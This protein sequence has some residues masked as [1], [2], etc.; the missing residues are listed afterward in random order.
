[1]FNVPYR[2]IV[3][4]IP[5]E[6]WT[7]LRDK[8]FW[9]EYMNCSITCFN[10]YLPK[11]LKK[12]LRKT[13]ELKIGIICILHPFGKDMKFYPHLHLLITEDG[14]DKKGKFIKVKYFPAKAFRRCWQYVVLDKFQELGL[15]KELATQLYQI[16]P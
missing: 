1:M 14:F 6:L 3:F 8:S 9:K 12:K 10:N 5:P 13:Y 4:S 15:L 7:F 11:M 16:V 2:H